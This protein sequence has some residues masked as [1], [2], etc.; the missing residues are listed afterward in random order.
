MVLG[1]QLEGEWV[2]GQGGWADPD[3]SAGG[4]RGRHRPGVL[5]VPAPHPLLWA[6]QFLSHH[7]PRGPV[8]SPGHAAADSHGE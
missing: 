5:S 6:H 3:S 7:Q 1:Q 8:C 2:Q 4:R